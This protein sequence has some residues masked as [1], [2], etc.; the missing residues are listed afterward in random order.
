ME[1][2]DKGPIII[3]RPS[4]QPKPQIALRGLGIQDKHAEFRLRP[5]GIIE[6]AVYSQEALDNT[7]VNGERLEEDDEYEDLWITPLQH[8]DRIVFG[9]AIFLFRYPL[10]FTFKEERIK[11]IIQNLEEQDCD[12]DEVDRVVEETIES[13]MIIGVGNN[14]TKLDCDNYSN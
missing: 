1:G 4:S 8:L 7:L 5:N 9:N 3:G 6:L 13:L 14:V 12:P 11:D 10:L 2:I